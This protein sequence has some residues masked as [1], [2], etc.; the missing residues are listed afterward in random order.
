MSTL[1]PTSSPRRRKRHLVPE[2]V[3][4]QEYFTTT[5]VSAMLGGVSDRVLFNLRAAGVLEEPTRPGGKIN[6]WSAAQVDR[7]RAKMEALAV[8]ANARKAAPV[9][10]VEEALS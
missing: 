8:E 10:P 6:L 3:I 7:F 4:R 5:D 2:R 9:A 1:D